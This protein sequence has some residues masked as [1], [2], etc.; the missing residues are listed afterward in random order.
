MVE[1]GV[2]GKGYFLRGVQGRFLYEGRGMGQEKGGVLIQTFQTH[3]RRF[4][5]D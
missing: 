1:V 3:V 5:T 2:R 4:Q